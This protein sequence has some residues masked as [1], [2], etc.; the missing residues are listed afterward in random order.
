MAIHTKEGA[1]LQRKEVDDCT[2]EKSRIADQSLDGLRAGTRDL[3][4]AGFILS[5]F[6]HSLTLFISFL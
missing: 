6:C 3:A 5:H 1:E 2:K 4:S